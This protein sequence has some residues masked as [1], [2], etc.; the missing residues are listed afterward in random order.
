MPEIIKQ[1]KKPLITLF[2]PITRLWTM[3]RFLKSID[4]LEIPREETEIVFYIDSNEDKLIKTVRD[5]LTERKEQYNGVKLYLSGNLPP[6]ETSIKKQRD[7][8]VEMKEKSKMLVSGDYVFGLEDDTLV[9]SH[10]FNKLYEVINN[11]PDIGYIEGVEAG[12]HGVK[13]VGVWRCDNVRSPRFQGTLI[14]PEEL[15]DENRL[16]QITGGGF[17]CYMTLGYL[18]KKLN[19]RHWAECFGP[20]VC[21]VMDVIQEGYKAYVDWSLNVIHMGQSKDILVE[22]ISDV[23]WERRI[24]GVWRLQPYVAR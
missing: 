9:P 15:N 8:I 5:Y 11:D 10:A 23:H 2:A 18:Y 3:D 20:D 4:E 17:Y 7:R 22:K 14:P 13:M 6:T 19:Y 16:E 21:F 12:R 24:D 1:S